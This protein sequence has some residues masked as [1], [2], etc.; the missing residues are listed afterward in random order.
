[1][2]SMSRILYQ[3]SN[4]FNYLQKGSNLYQGHQLSN[5]GHQ[6]TKF[7]WK[8]TIKSYYKS[9]SRNRIKSFINQI[10]SSIS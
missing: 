2:D 5:E 6:Y 4:P 7:V 10:A 9:I 3:V 8:V 1:M